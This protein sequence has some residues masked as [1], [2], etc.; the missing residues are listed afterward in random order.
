MTT[1]HQIKL[2]FYENRCLCLSFQWITVLFFTNPY[3]KIAYVCYVANIIVA[4]VN[5]TIYYWFVH[6]SPAFFAYFNV[7]FLTQITEQEKRGAFC[8]DKMILV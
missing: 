8:P 3:V 7:V 4:D 2:F 6:D 5:V 1:G